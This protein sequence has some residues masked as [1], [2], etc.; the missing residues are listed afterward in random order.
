MTKCIKCCEVS[1]DKLTNFFC[2][3]CGYLNIFQHI[4]YFN[5]LDLP[6]SLSVNLEDLEEK[7]LNLMML[8]HPDK[9]INKDDQQQQND[10]ISSP[11]A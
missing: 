6:L 1:V 2:E 3:K 8:Y 10:K 5:Y 11:F 7:Y 4:N 9:F